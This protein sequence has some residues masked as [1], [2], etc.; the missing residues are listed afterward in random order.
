MLDSESLKTFDSSRP[1][2]PKNKLS[3]FLFA[4]FLISKRLIFVLSQH[5]QLLMYK[6]IFH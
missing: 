5:C 6:Y 1:E 3:S 4:I 2:Q